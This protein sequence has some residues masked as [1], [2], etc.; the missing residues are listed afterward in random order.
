MPNRM[1]LVEDTV[2]L[3]ES[4]REFLEARGFS[5]EIESR[6]ERALERLVGEPWDVAAVDVMLPGRFDGLELCRRVRAS[7][8]AAT[9]LLLLTAL[10]DLEDKLVGFEAGAD[11]YLTKPF[12]LHELLARL[13]AL[14]GRRGRDG[15]VLR[16]GPLE[17]DLGQQVATRDGVK[18]SLSESGVKLL[19]ELMRAAPNFVDRDRL[20]RV[21][22]PRQSPDSDAL[23]TH[24][25]QLR[26][27]I[28]RPFE[29]EMLKTVRG[30]GYRIV[31][32]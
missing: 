23:K 4:V 11:D 17:L 5:V 8:A 15:T 10:S 13:R 14:L 19:A 27:V 9:P 18:L 30:R 29:R 25:Y 2:D 32:P 20:G 24:M 3:A 31:A 12:S 7:S 1:L 21:L 16:V 6:S 26:R 28:D 22:W